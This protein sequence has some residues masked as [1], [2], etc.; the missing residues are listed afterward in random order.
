LFPQAWFPKEHVQ[1]KKAW[2]SYKNPLQDIGQTHKQ[3]ATIE[4]CSLQTIRESFSLQL[5]GETRVKYLT[6]LVCVC[7]FC[8]TPLY[9]TFI[10]L[11]FDV[12]FRL[13]TGWTN[14]ADRS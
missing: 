8:A 6:S 11:D 5:L 2:R 3:Q 10:K 13:Q 12:T 14:C 4:G 7:I 9:C 1:C